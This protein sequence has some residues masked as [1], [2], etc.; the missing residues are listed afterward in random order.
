MSGNTKSAV[1]TQDPNGNVMVGEPIQP[2]A[3]YPSQPIPDPVYYQPPKAFYTP[4]AKDG[5][6]P[7]PCQQPVCEPPA[8]YYAPTGGPGAPAYEGPV[9]VLPAGRDEPFVA[10]TSYNPHAEVTLDR[11]GA[12]HTDTG[13][14]LENDMSGD[15][16]HIN[17]HDNRLTSLRG[18]DA[19]PNLLRLTVSWND[20]TTLQGVE[21][22]PYLRWIDAAGNHL[23]DFGGMKSLPSLEWLNLTQSDITS[24]R[25][26]EF[27]PNL[28]WLC[29]H[30]NHFNN[31]AGA[32]KL[33]L[34]FLDV[35]DN[36]VKNV[37]GL[38]RCR[39]LREINLCNNPM[40]EGDVKGNLESVKALA[41]LPNLRRLNINDTFYDK[42][43]DE[44]GM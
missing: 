2:A 20:L 37:Q 11:S 25:G 33:Q 43:E 8:Y 42:E 18:L 24:F 5:V 44:V 21:A 28:T 10:N 40:C 17:F 9:G 12:A 30:H 36:D 1:F 13:K 14:V 3:A 32:D 19:F 26:L 27:A 15:V 22:A 4:P 34:Q 6:Q 41:T 38:E 39:T 35:S 16:T 31:F 29:L 23:V 7:T